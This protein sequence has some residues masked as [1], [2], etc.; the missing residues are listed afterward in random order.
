M[1]INVDDLLKAVF[2]EDEG[3]KVRVNRELATA[4]AKIAQEKR[5]MLQD[6]LREASETQAKYFNQKRIDMQFK[7]GEWVM[8]RTKNITP[9]GGS[10]KFDS[11]QIGPFQVIDAWNNAYRLLLTPRY[12]QLHP[13]FH[14][15][16]LEPHRDSARTTNPPDG[17]L[18]NG[19]IEYEV[20]EIR[21]EKQVGRSKAKSYL[22]KWKGYPEEECTWEPEEHVADTAAM[23]RYLER[24]KPVQ[25]RAKRRKQN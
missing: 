8:L 16:L 5:T 2:K 20:E 23:N 9:P 6:V 11:K 15:S 21:M 1:R 19:H 24:P 13:V 7:I 25:R 14:V 10:K 4:Y 3:P 12:R 22:V 17:I 18:V